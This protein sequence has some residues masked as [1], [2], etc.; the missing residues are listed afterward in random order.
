MTASTIAIDRI[1]LASL[2]A[3]EDLRVGDFVTVLNEFVEFPSFLWCD[4]VP[5]H[6]EELVR[7][8]FCATEGGAPL[9][10]RAICL[11]F[12]YVKSPTGA[13]QT[14]DL[15]RVEL[16]RLKSRY[17]KT[18]NRPTAATVIPNGISSAPRETVATQLLVFPLQSR[19]EPLQQN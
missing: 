15:R 10:V 18:K 11:P 17:S 7:M 6:T 8:Q 16:V 5:K 14:I 9:K 1:S 2:V 13:I 19:L 12:V 3:H 4:S